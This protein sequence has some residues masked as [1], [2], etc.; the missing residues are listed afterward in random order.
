VCLLLFLGAVCLLFLG[1]MFLDC[2]LLFLGAMC[3]LLFLG[4]LFFVTYIS[5]I[6]N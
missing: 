3:L 4:T 6:F 5:V 1:A 2:L